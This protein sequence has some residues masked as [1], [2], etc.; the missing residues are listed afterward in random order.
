MFTQT[1]IAVGL[2]SRL[3][4]CQ[5]K[6]ANVPIRTEAGIEARLLLFSLPLWKRWMKWGFQAPMRNCLSS[7]FLS[8]FFWSSIHTPIPIMLLKLQLADFALITNI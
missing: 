4:L 2:I 6:E 7:R 3:T 1:R 8:S 5:K